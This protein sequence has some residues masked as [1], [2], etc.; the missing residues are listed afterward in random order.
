VLDDIDLIPTMDATEDTVGGG[1]VDSGAPAE[2]GDE[3][4]TPAQGIAVDEDDILEP[5]TGKAELGEAL[6]SDPPDFESP[7]YEFKGTGFGLLLYQAA[8]GVFLLVGLAGLIAGSASFLLSD[9][10]PPQV[11]DHLPPDLLPALQ[12]ARAEIPEGAAKLA[13]LFF[14]PL[15]V[16]VAGL[17]LAAFFFRG[18][19]HYRFRHTWIHLEPVNVKIGLGATL[20]NHAIHLVLF[21]LSAGL[22]T[23]WIISRNVRFRMQRCFVKARRREKS[24][25]FAGKGTQVLVLGLLT[26]FTAPLVPLTLGVW[27]VYLHF[28]WI[29]WEQ[30]H[31]LVPS[32]TGR[33][34][35]QATFHGTWS[36]LL[37][38]LLLNTLLVVL[39]AGL[40]QPWATTAKW[41][42]IARHTKIPPPE[43]KPDRKT[44]RRK[45]IR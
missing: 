42:W 31:T 11:A 5:I 2:P 33:G 30:S 40:F 7:D 1:F 43:E 25:D 38:R 24:L 12:E 17:L 26:A 3:A 37:G 14:V 22:A 34:T 19:R 23:P 16:G 15:G 13:D 6:A 32:P 28:L 20:V 45:K 35:I 9:A 39:T 21:A 8:L 4:P 10:V 44:R 27:F 36:S 18:V 29:R 41:R